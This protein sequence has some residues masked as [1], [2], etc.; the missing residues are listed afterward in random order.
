MLGKAF[1]GPKTT[2]R[3]KIRDA[4]EPL[5]S[6]EADQLMDEDAIGREAVDLVQNDGIVFL[7][8][9]DKIVKGAAF[10]YTKPYINDQGQKQ[11]CQFP[12]SQGQTPVEATCC[13]TS[14]LGGPDLNQ[15]DRCDSSPDTWTTDTWSALTFQMND[16]HYFIYSFDSFGTLSA[17]KFTTSAFGDLDCDNIQSTFQ[18]IGWGD[19][20]ANYAECAMYG[21]PAFFVDSET[22]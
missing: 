6:E 14:A 21:S 19:P 13:S 20:Q 17:A 8:E 18:R 16:E 11:P 7:D 15:D 10:Y 22:E 1:Q 4:Y 5:L 3:I 9:I 2:K 12:A